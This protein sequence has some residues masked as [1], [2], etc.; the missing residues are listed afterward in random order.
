MV[1]SSACS[2]PRK[3]ERGSNGEAECMMDDH[4]VRMDWSKG[5][6]DRRVGGMA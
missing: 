5:T 1:L 6:V 3:C 4:C 2:E